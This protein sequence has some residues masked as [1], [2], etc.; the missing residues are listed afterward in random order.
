MKRIGRIITGIILAIV[1]QASVM[2]VYAEDY[3]TERTADIAVTGTAGSSFTVGIPTAVVLTNATHNSDRATGSFNITAVGTIDSNY[4]LSIA[5]VD[6][7]S[8]ATGVNFEI[9]QAGNSSNKILVNVND[10]KT[11]FTASELASQQ[12][13]SCTLETAHKMTPGNWS[14]VLRYNISLVHV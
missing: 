14:G 8:N 10:P 11:T 6:T 12:N 9:V 2:P 13:V 5:P 1:M 7:V 3:T 4:M